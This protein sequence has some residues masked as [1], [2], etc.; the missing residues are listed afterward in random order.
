MRVQL[1]IKYCGRDDIIFERIVWRRP[2]PKLSGWD[3]K[4]MYQR[5]QS[6]GEDHEL[7]DR[8]LELDQVIFD[9]QVPVSEPWMSCQTK[10][11]HDHGSV[12]VRVQYNGV[13]VK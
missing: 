2:L 5:V 10:L 6:L 8:E 12:K 3:P 1:N 7:L 4:F 13:S 11:N 9:D